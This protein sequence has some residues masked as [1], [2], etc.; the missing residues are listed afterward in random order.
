M[1]IFV[2][3]KHTPR[4]YALNRHKV[5]GTNGT[6]LGAIGHLYSAVIASEARQSSL[7]AARSATLNSA[8]RVIPTGL[9][10]SLRLLAMTRLK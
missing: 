4:D 9:Q 8:Q 3:H 7:K 1:R 10:Q 5:S 6:T 2:K